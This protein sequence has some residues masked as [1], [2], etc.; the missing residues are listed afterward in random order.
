YLVT[1]DIS[2]SGD[3][4]RLMKGQSV[5]I[6]CE[7]PNYFSGAKFYLYKDNDQ[8]FISTTIASS[9]LVRSHFKLH[10]ITKEDQ[11]NYSCS[12]QADIVG[13]HFNSSRSDPIYLTVID[14]VALRLVNGEND[15]S[16]TVQV[17]Y[18]ATW[19]SVCGE[20]WGITDV[21]VVCR[22][23]GCGFAKGQM[24]P[25]QFADIQKPIWLSMVQCSGAE[26]HL[27][28]CPARAWI[29]GIS[30]DRLNGATATCSAQPPPPTLAVSGNGL[31]FKEDTIKFVCGASSLYKG[32][33]MALYKMGEETPVLTGVIS[34]SQ[35]NVKFDLEHINKSHE[36]T[37]W[38]NYQLEVAELVFASEDSALVEIAVV[39]NAKLRLVDG[40]TSC[41]GRVEAFYNGTWGTICDFGWDIVD[42][43]VV[44]HQ[45]GCGFGQS[46]TPGGHFGEGAGPILL[47][48]VRC[49][50]TEKFLWSCPSQVIMP[51]TCRQNNDAGV[52]CSGKD[53]AG[54][55][56]SVEW[57]VPTRPRKW[58]PGS[59]GRW[60]NLN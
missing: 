29:S 34:S 31:F 37:Y 42:A 40:P 15:C 6:L 5:E 49:N 26:A 52:I 4:S 14:D 10:H 33:Q 27:W 53:L 43:Q 11:G 55:C 23:L 59:C 19:G 56:P 18:N 12:Y 25:S 57:E 54:R 44:C 9:R 8:N 20:F 32:A 50:G 36:G 45:V 16:G 38:C 48:N 60:E 35:G 28:V 30:C 1:P 41:S 22:Q 51:R 21:Q 17:Y 24:D 13:K 58:G 39:E 2:V 3:S 46:A 47:E 7:A